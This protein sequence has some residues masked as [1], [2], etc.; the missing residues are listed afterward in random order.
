MSR[1]RPT[2]K[3][4]FN[5][6]LQDMTIQRQIRHQPVQSR[7]LI[8]QLTQF[9]NLEQSEVTVPLLPHV[10]R[11]LANAHLPTDIA[12]WL[13]RLRLLQG[14][15][16]LLL[17]KLRLFHRFLSLPCKDPGSTLLQF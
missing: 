11:R 1:R 15:Q 2:A 16:D 17:G 9:T 13:P 8:A 10:K 3:S 7:V 6:F 5:D 12:D 4:F 14:E